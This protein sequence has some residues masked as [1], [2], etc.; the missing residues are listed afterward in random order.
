MIVMCTVGLCLSVCLSVSV[1]LLAKLE[2]HTAKLHQI[3]GACC[4][5]PWFR[6]SLRALRYVM[7]ITSCFHIMGLWRVMCIHKWR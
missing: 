2:N 3:F 4:F 1:C 7:W 6:P 5:W